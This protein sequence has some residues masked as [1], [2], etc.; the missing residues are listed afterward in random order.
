MGE[1]F[2]YLWQQ[3]D[4]DQDLKQK[5]LQMQIEKIEKGT[6]TDFGLSKVVERGTQSLTIFPSGAWCCQPGH[7]A[8]I[9][10]IQLD[11]YF[12]DA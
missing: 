4:Y 12:F 8:A 2:D 11:R 9:E 5:F 6:F 7:V 10:G 3:R 1:Y